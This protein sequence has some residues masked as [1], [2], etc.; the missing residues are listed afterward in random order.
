[1]TYRNERYPGGSPRLDPAGAEKLPQIA[2]AVPAVQA[3][4]RR[5]A[6]FW[7]DRWMYLLMLPGLIYFVIFRYVPLLGNIIA[8]QDYSP[9]LG[10]HSPFIGLKNFARLATDPDVGI[11]RR[12]TT[13]VPTQAL[14]LLNSPFVRAQARSAATRL[15]AEQ[16]SDAE[17]VVRLYRRALGRR[18]TTAEVAR[19]LAF[20]AEGER[21]EAWAAACQAV[22][23]CT[24]FRFAE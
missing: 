22:V 11:G 20:V 3:R 9:F 16:G 6:Q 19:I 8:F 23:G 5:Q 4:S 15:L 2:R 14:F 13:T 24:E 10:F 1:M 18:P 7:R 12:D 17:R 21:A